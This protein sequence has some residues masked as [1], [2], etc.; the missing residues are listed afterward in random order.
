MALR[1]HHF[2]SSMTVFVKEIFPIKH[3]CEKLHVIRFHPKPVLLDALDCPMLCFYRI[4]E[5]KDW[6]DWNHIYSS[7][8]AEWLI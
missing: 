5:G 1:F 4:L 3:K 7:A 6:G 2:D 8:S